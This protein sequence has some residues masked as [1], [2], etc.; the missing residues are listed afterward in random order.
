VKKTIR[1]SRQL[2]S[3]LVKLYPA[4]LQHHFA[5][6]MVDVFELQLAEACAERG[7]L[8]LMR[9][10]NCVLSEVFQGPG[11]LRLF[12]LVVSVPT[13]ALVSSSALFLLFFW[14][15]GFTKTCR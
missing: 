4:P 12:Q 7:F 6:E 14:I 3:V 1:V 8:G 13:I 10:W 2:Y 15:T 9:V 11:P 5:A